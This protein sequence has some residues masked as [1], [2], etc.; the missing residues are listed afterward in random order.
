MAYLADTNV[1]TRWTL[2]QDPLYPVCRTAVR[3]LRRRGENVYITPQIVMEY[4]ALGTRP[5]QANGLGLSAEQLALRVRLLLRSFVLLPDTPDI[6][7]AWQDLVE[8]N[9]IVGRQVYDARLVAVM[10]AHGIDQ[11]LTFNGAHFRR[12]PG[13]TVVEPQAI[14]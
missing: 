14:V 4:W 8:R 5:I 3:T 9:G 10:Q 11:V 7:P 6:F 1:V 13:I 2:I 12:F